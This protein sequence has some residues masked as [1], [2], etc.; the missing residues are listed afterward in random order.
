[1]RL[2]PHRIAASALIATL[3][4]C[5]IVG[6]ALAE[7]QSISIQCPA[8]AAVGSTPQI[9]VTLDNGD[10]SPVGVRIL[11]SLTANQ[12]ETL[13]GALI[14]GPAVSATSTVD[15][16]STKVVSIDAL[17][18]I[19]SSFANRLATYVVASEWGGTKVESRECLVLVPEPSQ[20]VQALALIVWL[21]I[22]CRR[23]LGA[24]TREEDSC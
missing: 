1:V 21:A 5:C 23:Q 17:P 18:R 14:G 12:N 4:V 7:R 13:E 22:R 2:E 19:P 11:S 10:S 15:G 24:R 16:L 20:D 8:S 6:S 9:S 3:A